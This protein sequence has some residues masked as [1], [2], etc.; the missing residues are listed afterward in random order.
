MLIQFC[1]DVAFIS[2]FYSLDEH[3]S[4][5]F[6]SRYAFVIMRRL[7]T[8]STETVQIRLEFELIFRFQCIFLCTDSFPI[9]NIFHGCKRQMT[10]EIER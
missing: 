1:F 3:F 5:I 9:T 4:L 2:M 6:N 10:I 7:L 8:V